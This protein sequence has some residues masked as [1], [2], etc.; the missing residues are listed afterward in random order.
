M[1]RAM[2]AIIEPIRSHFQAQAEACA[3]RGSPFTAAVLS[4]L[5]EALAAG[6]P[7]LAPVAHYAGDPWSGALALRIAGALHRI[8]QDGRDP[9]LARLYRRGD[10]SLARRSAGLLASTLSANHDLLEAYLVDAPQTNEPARSAM[11]LG[12]FLTVAAAIRLPLAVLEVGA[13][14]GLNLVFDRYRYDFG[15]WRWGADGA[16]PTIAA[17]WAGQRPPDVP[18]VVIERRGCDSNPLDLRD[19]AARRRLRSYVWPDQK[20]RLRRLDAAIAA[21]LSVDPPVVDRADAADWLPSRLDEP[22]PG[23]VTVVMH[24]IVWQYLTEDGR[25]RI[26]AAIARRGAATEAGA[27]PLAWLRLEPEPGGAEPGLRLTLWPG[28][29]EWLL[30]IGDYHGRHMTWLEQRQPP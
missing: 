29:R 26:T 24:S 4:A 12:G 20:D 13:S 15:D 22:R 30:G 27:P 11:L 18:L 1:G 9:R 23:R 6:T 14:A 16:V 19:D 28:R 21:A 3:R 2:Q 5:D 10:A 8:A 7:A 25:A 17:T